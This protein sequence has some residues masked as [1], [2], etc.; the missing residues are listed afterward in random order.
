[1]QI[2]SY[3]WK[4]FFTTL[5]YFYNWQTFLPCN[6]AV[7]HVVSGKMIFEMSITLVYFYN[8][9]TFLPCN[10]AVT[11]VVSC[12][13]SLWRFLCCFLLA[14][15]LLFHVR[16]LFVS[17]IWKFKITARAGLLD[18]LCFLIWWHFKYHLPRNHM[19]DGIVAW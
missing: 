10:N 6:N 11:H 8:W 3:T 2:Y 14:Y 15:S 12:K 1:L 17:F 19:S 16:T 9:Q 13:F 5:V 18:Q 7:T 4:L